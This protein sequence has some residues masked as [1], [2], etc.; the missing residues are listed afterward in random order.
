M[1][2]ILTIQATNALYAEVDGLAKLWEGLDK[3]V[4]S[5]VYELK[6]GE[7]RISRLTTE[8]GSPILAG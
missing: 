5:K 7:M 2:T 8:V 6:D 3:T 4:T 1:Q